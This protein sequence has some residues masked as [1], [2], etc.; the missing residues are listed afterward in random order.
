MVACQSV[1]ALWQRLLCDSDEVTDAFTPTLLL[2][3]P[4]SRYLLLNVL[5]YI[6][7]PDIIKTFLSFQTED[8]LSWQDML[9]FVLYV[10]VRDIQLKM[11]SVVD[12]D[13]C[14]QVV[15][16]WGNT[17]MSGFG[18]NMFPTKQWPPYHRLVLSLR[19]TVH[20]LHQLVVLF[21]TVVVQCLLFYHL[22]K[23]SLFTHLVRFS[24]S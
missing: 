17:M 15:F 19:L 23:H 3:K 9:N 7:Q 11:I 12:T 24:T 6:Y 10:S 5:T 18:I 1:P 14:V 8:K 2:N 21:T 22:N 20:N 16:L 4:S 13:Q